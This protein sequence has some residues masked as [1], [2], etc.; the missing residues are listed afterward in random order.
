LLDK[1]LYPRQSPNH[2][3]PFVPLCLEPGQSPLGWKGGIEVDD[4]LAMS[5]QT[6]I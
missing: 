2:H 3:R 5:E 1:R 6:E 4:A